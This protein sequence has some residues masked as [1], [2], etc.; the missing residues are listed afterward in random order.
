[1]EFKSMRSYDTHGFR[2]VDSLP[3]RTRHDKME[4]AE[5]VEYFHISNEKVMAREFP[6]RAEVKR[7][8][9]GIRNAIKAL[10]YESEMFPVQNNLTVYIVKGKREDYR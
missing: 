2:A 4:F 5:L 10:G 1:M 9:T 6:D 7:V 3:T 8:S